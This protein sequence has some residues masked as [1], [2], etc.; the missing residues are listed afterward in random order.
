MNRVLACLPI[1]ALAALSYSQSLVLNHVTVIDATGAPARP[2]TVVVITGGRIANI[3]KRAALPKDAQT[4][5][6]TG[7]FLIPGL[8]DMH[9]HPHR[10]DDLVLFIANE[11]PFPSRPERGS[12]ER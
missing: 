6:A 11:R 4:V 2:D 7:K 1:L 12:R 10:P 5:D 9:G 8:W 3:G